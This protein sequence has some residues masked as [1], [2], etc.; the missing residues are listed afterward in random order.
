MRAGPVPG[1]SW[2]GLGA[3]TRVWRSCFEIGAFVAIVIAD[4]FGLV[5]LTQTILLLP[6]VWISLR[7]R[8]E[9]W[10]TIGFSA[11]QRLRCCSSSRSPGRSRLSVKRF[12]CADS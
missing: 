5:P 7:L 4:A 2:R 8:R 9:V 11:P 6:L 1:V 3:A 10:S 12:V